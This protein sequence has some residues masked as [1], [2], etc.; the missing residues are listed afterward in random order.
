MTA[1]TLVQEREEENCAPTFADFWLLYPKRVAR[2]EAEKAWQRLSS[3]Q[4]AE[5]IVGL[6]QWRSIWIAEGRLQFVPNAS[7]WL[8][9]QR[10]TDELPISWGSGHASHRTA[11]LPEPGERV[12]MPEHVRALIA[13]LR[14]S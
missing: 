12:A 11:A 5:A 8:N 10:W 1:L 13:K 2:M 9:Q 7:T 6:C 14:K 4:G 3:A